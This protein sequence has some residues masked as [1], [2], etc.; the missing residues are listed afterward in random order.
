MGYSP[1]GCTESDTTDLAPTHLTT[2][3]SAK[4]KKKKDQEREEG[5]KEEKKSG[6]MDLMAFVDI[7]GIITITTADF[8]LPM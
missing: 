5:R 8:K 3:L 7:C 2:G 1:K 4:E 6:R